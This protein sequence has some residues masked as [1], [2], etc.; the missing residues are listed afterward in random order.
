MF[1]KYNAK[2]KQTIF[3]LYISISFLVIACKTSPKTVPYTVT[4]SLIA[5]TAMV[6]A[7]HPLASQAGIEILQQGGIYVFIV[8]IFVYARAMT[9]LDRKYDVHEDD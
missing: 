1:N 2:M 5:D 4:Q 3:L 9:R 7:A 8:L 6:V